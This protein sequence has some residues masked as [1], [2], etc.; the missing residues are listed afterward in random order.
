M[1]IR[2]TPLKI[3]Y[4][5]NLDFTITPNSYFKVPV[6]DKWVNEIKKVWQ[7]AESTL[8]MINERIKCFYDR[9]VKDTPEFKP[10]DKV[11]KNIKQSWPNWKLQDCW[12]GPF[13]ILERIGLVD[14][15][16]IRSILCSML[17]CSLN[18]RKN[19]YCHYGHNGCYGYYDKVPIL[20]AI[21][22]ATFYF[23]VHY[24]PL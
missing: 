5:Y 15:K 22:A 8:K 20:T 24:D 21:I 23:F 11:C 10:G 18:I 19:G 2:Y 17:N 9:S 7:D 16:E 3:I 13:K 6:T 4:S 1:T 12:L 14:T